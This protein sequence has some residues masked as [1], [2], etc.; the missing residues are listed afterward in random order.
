MYT[1]GN[2]LNEAVLTCSMSYVLS[3]NKKKISLFSSDNY[4]F[5]SRENC[6]ILHWRIILI[7]KSEYCNEFQILALTYTEQKKKVNT[8]FFSVISKKELIL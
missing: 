6:S 4:G 3:K 7:E 2:R 1:L 8:Y 5:Y